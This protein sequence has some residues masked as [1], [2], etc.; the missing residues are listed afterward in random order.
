MMKGTILKKSNKLIKTMVITVALLP[1]FFVIGDVKANVTP[2]P[3]AKTEI[4]VSFL[5]NPDI[6]EM[7]HRIIPDGNLPLQVS[8]NRT[9]LRTGEREEKEMQI[10]GIVLLLIIFLIVILMKIRKKKDEKQK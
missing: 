10:L 3:V 7:D 5:P 6:G 1:S 9:L 8:S 4:G 2:T